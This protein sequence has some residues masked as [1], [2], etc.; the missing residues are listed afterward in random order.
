VG[1]NG[2]S[3]KAIFLQQSSHR[4]WASKREARKVTLVFSKL[5]KAVLCSS[6]KVDE[7]SNPVGNEMNSLST[8]CSLTVRTQVEY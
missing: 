1:V 4:W 2:D 7:P 8:F 5:G 3:L 6:N